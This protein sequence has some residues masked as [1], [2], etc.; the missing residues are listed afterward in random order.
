MLRKV[1]GEGITEEEVAVSDVNTSQ[2]RQEGSFQACSFLCFGTFIGGIKTCMSFS[3]LLFLI[4]I[5]LPALGLSCVMWD[6]VPLTSDQTW[7]S[8]TGSAVS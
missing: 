7:T 5:Y 8:C 4:F 1:R 6:L 3:F 2:C